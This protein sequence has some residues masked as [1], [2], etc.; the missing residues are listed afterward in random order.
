MRKQLDRR[1]K[2][3]DKFESS[4]KTYAET[5]AAW[6]RKF[7]AKEGE[8]ESIKV[9]LIVFRVLSLLTFF[10][11]TNAD[12][13]TQL[14]SQKRPGQTDG[15]EVRA[16]SA[17][18]TN[19]ERRLINAQNQLVAAEEKMALMNQKNA[20]ADN[21]WEVRV[22]EY[23]SRLK[24]AE[25]RVKRERQGSKERVAELENNLKSVPFFAQISIMELMSVTI[26]VFN[27]NSNSLRS[28]ISNSTRSLT[29]HSLRLHL[30]GDLFY[31]EPFLR[32]LVLHFHH[33][34]FVLC[35]HVSVLMT[36]SCSSIPGLPM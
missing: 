21:K 11:A 14:A 7:S 35:T 26:G 27:A 6:R 3:I 28:A 9:L 18:A 24:A 10:Q 16:L 12:M 22:K 20:S 34:Y 31:S 19:A 13:A 5:K 32:F 33:A 25:E 2:Q 17:R 30:Y 8:L 23:E 1:W 36:T 15:M 29:R 4:V